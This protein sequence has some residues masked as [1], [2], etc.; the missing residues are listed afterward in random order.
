MD[1][2]VALCNISDA[3][4]PRVAYELLSLR[5]ASCIALSGPLVPP[6]T[7]EHLRGENLKTSSCSPTAAAILSRFS[8]G[9]LN[10]CG[11]GSCE[12]ADWTKQSKYLKVHDGATP[13]FQSLADLCRKLHDVCVPTV[14]FGCYAL[15]DTAVRLGTVLHM[16]ICWMKTAPTPVPHLH[17]V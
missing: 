14:N 6:R 17:Y 13:S 15:G 2:S 9:R 11:A 5:V 7:K 1:L 8:I 4:P 12:V 10:A 16:A 3:C